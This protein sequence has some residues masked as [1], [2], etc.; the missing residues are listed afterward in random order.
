LW[1]VGSRLQLHAM[2]GHSDGVRCVVWS[3][4]SKLLAS[5]SDDQ[6]VNVWDVQSGELIQVLKGHTGG[7]FAVD[8]HR[9]G[10]LLASRWTHT[11]THANHNYQWPTT[12]F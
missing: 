1:G 4:D 12:L 9:G 10:D 7:V 11:H 3:P 5:G 2:H 8:W 6:L